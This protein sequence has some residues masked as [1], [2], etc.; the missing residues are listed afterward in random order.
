MAH[1][2]CPRRARVAGSYAR[3]AS[4]RMRL[5]GSAAPCPTESS[6]HVR[7]VFQPASASSWA[8]DDVFLDRYSRR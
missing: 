4:P 2:I 7:L 8:I 5:G 3:A 1:P 6:L